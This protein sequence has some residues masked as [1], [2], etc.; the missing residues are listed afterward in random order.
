MSAYETENTH[1]RCQRLCDRVPQEYYKLGIEELGIQSVHT[2][3]RRERASKTR[4][5]LVN[6]AQSP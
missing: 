5:F 3:N 6:F 4:Y 1:N 2:L